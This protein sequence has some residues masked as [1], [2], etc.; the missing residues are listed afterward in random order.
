MKKVFLTILTFLVLTLGVNSQTSAVLNPV[1]ISKDTTQQIKNINKIC[2]NIKNNI[3]SY[4]KIEIF[5][6]SLSYRNVYLKDNV[7]QL[8]KVMYTE[9]N[10]EKNVDWYFLD[11]QLICAESI[12]ISLETKKAVD[13]IK[14]YFNNLHMI[15]WIDD[16]KYIDYKSTEFKAR[17]TQL[18]DYSKRI[19]VN[20]MKK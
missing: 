1:L 5:K 12:W 10:I 18:V 11:E 6:D 9:N 2:Q 7:L 17:E 14:C 13:N 20:A 19:W 8:V 15:A 4:L 3:N 16:N